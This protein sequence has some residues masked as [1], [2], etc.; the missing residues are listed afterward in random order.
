VT[1]DGKFAGLCSDWY[2]GREVP[3]GPHRIDIE[4]ARSARD[5]QDVVVPEGEQITVVFR[6]FPMPD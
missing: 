2:A 6:Y 3:P 4:T 5:G 1:I